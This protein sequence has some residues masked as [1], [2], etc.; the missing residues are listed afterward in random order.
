MCDYLSAHRFRLCGNL[1]HNY[2]AV[3][4]SKVI[5]SKLVAI[6][7][8]DQLL[9]M[10]PEFKENDVV[11]HNIGSFR[12]LR[13]NTSFTGTTRVNGQSEVEGLGKHKST[14]MLKSEQS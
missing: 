14:R 9:A 10:V 11:V 1:L 4:Q 6:I 3:S 7:V 5:Y 8:L 13:E 2:R 12:S